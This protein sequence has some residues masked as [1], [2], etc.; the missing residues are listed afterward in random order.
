GNGYID[1][2]ETNV[3]GSTS[4]GL[5]TADEYLWGDDGSNGGTANNGILEPGE[6]RAI[7][8]NNKVLDTSGTVITATNGDT[9]EAGTGLTR[10]QALAAV[11][12]VMVTLIAETPQPDKNYTTSA[13]G[14]S[15]QYREA[16][17]G[18]TVEPRNPNNTITAS[19]SLVLTASPLSV[20]CP[21]T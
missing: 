7:I 11:T 21:T 2:S 5:P 15:Y 14:S 18:A 16:V 4:G 9:R 17:V 12:R 1:G 6:I 8:E 20:T 13:H 10:A 19:A 3:N